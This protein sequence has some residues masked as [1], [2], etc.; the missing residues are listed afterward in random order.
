M[1]T[2]YELDCYRMHAHVIM[3]MS[4]CTR[5]LAQFSTVHYILQYCSLLNINSTSAA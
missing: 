5:I 3:L 4:A 1:R 2:T